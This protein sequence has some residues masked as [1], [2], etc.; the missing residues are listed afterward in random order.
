MPAVAVLACVAVAIFFCFAFVLL[1]G[2]PFLPTLKPQIGAALDLL[3]LQPGET[4]LELG[5]GDGRVL[6]AAAKRGIKSVGYELNPILATIAWVRTRRYG[7]QVRI[8]WG[9][10]WRTPWPEAQGIFA[11]LLARYMGKLHKKVM[12]YPFKPVKVASFAFEINEMRT[13]RQ[14]RGI[15]LYFYEPD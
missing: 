8:V 9:D 12:Q 5:C 11:F 6:I 13:T 14:N 4:M 1:F 15:F 10:Y 2:A 3:D 7:K